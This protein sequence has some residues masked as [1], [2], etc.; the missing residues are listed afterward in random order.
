MSQGEDQGAGGIG[1]I[2]LLEV[3]ATK[4]HLGTCFTWKLFYQAHTLGTLPDLW[5]QNLHFSKIPGDLNMHQGLG[6]LGFGH[7]CS[8]FH[9]KGPAKAQVFKG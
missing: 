3:R 5:T 4:P 6:N 1:Q 7:T 2:L 8:R 9:L